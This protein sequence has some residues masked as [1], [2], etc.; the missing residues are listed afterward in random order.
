MS[1]D[2]IKKIIN[3]NNTFAIIPHKNPDGDAIGSSLALAYAL[4]KLGKTAKIFI[5]GDFPKNLNDIW[6]DEFV[7]T[8]LNEPYAAIVLDCA[9]FDRFD[10]KEKEIFENAK[11]TALIDH[12]ITN[13]GFADANYI[14]AKAAATGEIMYDFL[15]NVLN[16]EF[17]SE[18]AK[19]IYC[20]LV[21]DTGS[22]KYSN[23]TNKTLLVASKL[24]EYGIDPSY[25][26]Q[27]ILDQRSQKQVIAMKE[28]LNNL[29]FHLNGK[30]CVS[31]IT[32][33]F[34]EKNDLEFDDADFFVSF[35][36]DIENV[37][38][39]VYLKVRSENEIKVSLRSN[40]YV[41]VSRVANEFGGG[42]HVRAA[43]LT[44]N[45][46]TVEEAIKIILEKVEKAINER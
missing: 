11:E 31:Y 2:K 16:V 10:E 24:L 46:K 25:F 40:S 7:H 19:Y 27:K 28:C 44:I 34:I 9:S 38:V 18:L 17:D 32:Y 23:T 13:E 37:E 8:K 30:V 41:D 12:H 45:N 4:K 3:Q 1:F 35:P 20:A 36:R 42:G 14:D 39:G 26:S 5:S 21:C 6:T 29:S 33:E 22:F 43:G 15:H